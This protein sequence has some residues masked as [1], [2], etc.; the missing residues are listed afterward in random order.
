TRWPRDWS[1]DVCSSDLFVDLVVGGRGFAHHDEVDESV[2]VEVEECGVQAGD[3][4]QLA[5]QLAG[6]RVRLEGAVPA[7]V[8][9]PG[10]P[11]P[12]KGRHEQVEKAVVV[13]IAH[14][15]R[16]GARDS[17]ETARGG[18]VLEAPLAQVAELPKAPVVADDHEI[19][20]AVTVEVPERRIATAPAPAPA[21]ARETHRSGHFP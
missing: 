11:S 15:H 16:A 21:P 17:A 9:Q 12:V 8:V 20:V 7:V 13:V 18:R 10:C 3:A 5:P 1:S 14:G 2:V 6:P 4:A 19:G